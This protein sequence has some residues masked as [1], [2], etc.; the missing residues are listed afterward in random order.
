MFETVLL[1]PMLRPLVAGVGFA[2]DYELTLLAQEIAE[3]DTGGFAS[4]LARQ[5]RIAP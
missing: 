2:G 1:A 4:V 3:H 5:L